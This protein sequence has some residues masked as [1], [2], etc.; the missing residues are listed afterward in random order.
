M[1]LVFL[2]EFSG[3]YGIVDIRFIEIDAL[4]NRG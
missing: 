4:L 3:N 2:N 1:E